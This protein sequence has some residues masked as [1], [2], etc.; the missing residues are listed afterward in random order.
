MSNVHSGFELL[1]KLATPVMLFDPKTR[2]PSFCNKA[3]LS[4]F[5]ED[6]VLEPVLGLDRERV[7][8]ATAE[9][10]V[11]LPVT[12][13]ARRGRERAAQLAVWPTESQGAAVWVVEASDQRRAAEAKAMLDSFSAVIDRNNRDLARQKRSIEQLLHNMRQAVFAVD[14]RGRV[15]EPVSAFATSLFG[16]Q[17]VGR[18]LAEL[19][20][21]DQTIEAAVRLET[22]ISTSVG[23]D[24]L[25]WELVMDE[26]PE[27]LTIDR[28]DGGPLHIRM[29][30]NPIFDQAERIERLL[31]VVEDET[32]IRELVARVQEDSAQR[33]LELEVTQAFLDCDPAHVRDFLID[34][35]RLVE[36]GTTTD[37]A[38]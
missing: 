35:R 31:V 4:W 16:P 5:P 12:A 7:A 19:I 8:S 27:R 9:R 26:L 28:P 23:G 21:D 15:V 33:Q 34:A 2:V 38:R 17:V 10:P 13:V 25:Q 36:E 1:R 18:S 22:V 11:I 37:S 29:T 32:K 14:A 20:F 30:F 24:E 3:F 6:R